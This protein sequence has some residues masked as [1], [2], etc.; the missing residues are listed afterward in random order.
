[1]KVSESIVQCPLYV[2][3]AM[4]HLDSAGTWCIGSVVW[5]VSYSASG[6]TGMD[7]RLCAD[8]IYHLGMWPV[9]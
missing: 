5:H 1:M 9:S 8:I 2:M 6:S 7:D 3:H 4:Q